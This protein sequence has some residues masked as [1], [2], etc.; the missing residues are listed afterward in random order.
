MVA[1]IKRKSY[2]NNLDN[3]VYP[4]GDLFKDVSELDYDRS[5]QPL[6][7]NILSCP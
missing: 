6:R 2:V 1:L 5:S 3:S 7:H 4:Y